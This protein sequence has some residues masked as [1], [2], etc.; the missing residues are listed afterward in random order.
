MDG[1]AGLG[2]AITGGAGDIGA[3]MG[4]E[5]TRLGAAVALIDRKSPEE[6]EPWLERAARHG[7]V[8]AP[9]HGPI[10]ELVIPDPIRTLRFLHP[11]V[12]GASVLTSLGDL[13]HGLTVL[14]AGDA[15][16]LVNLLFRRLAPVHR[17]ACANVVRDERTLHRSTEGHRPSLRTGTRCR[18]H[19]PI[20]LIDETLKLSLGTRLPIDWRRQS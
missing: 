2:I 15:V 7:E 11:R 4:A 13:L 1:I 17:D 14:S 18:S 3:A 12:I 20:Q 8:A 16:A 6:A 9:V 5:L 19:V 10:L